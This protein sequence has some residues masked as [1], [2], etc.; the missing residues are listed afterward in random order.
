MDE[1]KAEQLSRLRGDYS[2]LQLHQDRAERLGDNQ[3]SLDRREAR[4]E[5]MAEEIKRP[6]NPPFEGGATTDA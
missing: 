6:K 3:E 4:L 1:L 5:A 2:A